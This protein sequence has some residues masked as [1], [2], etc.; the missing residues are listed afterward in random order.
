[1]L[2]DGSGGFGAATNTAAG[3]KPSAVASATSTATA[4]PIWSSPTPA[5]TPSRRCRNNGSGGFLAPVTYAV[6]NKPQAVALADL[7]GDGKLDI[8]VANGSGGSVSVLLTR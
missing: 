3:T 1:L 8:I 2:N 4:R 5:T 6:G 7:N